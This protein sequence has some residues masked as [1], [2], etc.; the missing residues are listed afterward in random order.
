MHNLNLCNRLIR[1]QNNSNDTTLL[2]IN[3]SVLN[4]CHLLQLSSLT[5]HLQSTP[6]QT[7][8]VWLLGSDQT[9]EEQAGPDN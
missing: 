1:I 7:S 2:N 5:R 9:L 8:K 3:L 4:L 6:L